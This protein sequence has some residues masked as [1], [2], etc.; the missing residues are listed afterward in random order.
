VTDLSLVLVDDVGTA[1]FAAAER[2]AL[3]GLGQVADVTYVRRPIPGKEHTH[4]AHEILMGPGASLLDMIRAGVERASTPRVAVIEVSALAS[5]AGAAGLALEL[6]DDDIDFVAAQ[7]AAPGGAVLFRDGAL[8][9]DGTPRFA[10]SDGLG[11]ELRT[12]RPTLICDPRA[13]AADRDMLL[14]SWRRGPMARD[15][16]SVAELAWRVWLLGGRA[17][18][19]ETVTVVATRD[20]LPR[21]GRAW[22]ASLGR[23]LED[24]TLRRT[25]EGA[26]TEGALAAPRVA[27]RLLRASG[28]DQPG[29]AAGLALREEVQHARSRQDQD[30]LWEGLLVESWESGGRAAGGRRRVAV[31]CSDAIGASMAGPAI[32]TIELARVLGREADVRIAARFGEGSAGDLPCPL[33]ELTDETVIELLG[34]ADALVLQGPLTDWHRAV[35]RS[36]LPIAIDLYDPLNLEALE[37]V[38]PDTL[39]PYTTNLLRDQLWRGDYFFCASERQR[40]FWL[41]MLA[42]TGRITPGR[43]EEHPDLDGLIGIV[44]YGISEEAPERVGEGVRAELDGVGPDDPLFV[45]NGGIWQWFDP[46]LLVLAIERLRAELPDVR[47]LFMGI[48]RPGSELTEEAHRLVALIDEHGLRDRNVFVRDWTPYAER[49]D[50]YLDATAVVS[51]HHAHIETRFSFRTR[52]LDCIWAATPIICTAGDVLAP[53][54]RDE[55]IGIAVPA[56]DLDAIVDALR[57]LATEPGL[58]ADMRARLRALAHRYHW[59]VA[60]APLVEWCAR[61]PVRRDERFVVTGLD[62]ALAGTPVLAPPSLGLKALV[63]R[64]VRQHVLGPLKRRLLSG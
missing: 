41:G 2:E 44:P 23:L 5:F 28:L 46:D 7:V 22:K 18:A 12:H 21:A 60:A 50:T 20:V 14:A 29:Q 59:E 52:L 54:V 57:K 62:P 25:P 47:A 3:R 16:T 38:D 37:S 1:F 30:L 17:V 8:A 32:R 61:T 24:E 58:V 53:I 45:W 26:D 51:L 10:S 4:D 15:A 27:T 43:Y 6:L 33:H 56:N 55:G 40:D 31:L 36:R 19:S 49:A 11:S 9:L 63:P 39:V 34:W 42:A 64:P 13:F 48:Q 35:L